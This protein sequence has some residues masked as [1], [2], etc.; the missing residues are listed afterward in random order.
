[1]RIYDKQSFIT[2]LDGAKNQAINIDINQTY[3]APK[4][5]SQ[6]H[7]ESFEKLRI[8]YGQF[9]KL[10]F[11]DRYF[12]LHYL[13]KG[14]I[15]LQLSE[16]IYSLKAPCFI[17][18]SPSVPHSFYTELDTVGHVLT[19][20]QQF[21][22][23]LLRSI[24]Q[25]NNYFQPL[26][27]E[28]AVDSSET[29]EIENILDKIV[30]EYEDSRPEKHTMLRLYAKIL[31]IN[32]ARLKEKNLQTAEKLPIKGGDIDLFNQFNQLIEQ[33]FRKNW[34]ISEYLTHLCISESRLNVLCKKFSG[35]S[36]K[37]IIIERQLQE[38]R[39]QLMFTQDSISKIAYDLGFSDP[40]YFSR[41][42]QARVGVSPKRFRDRDH[43]S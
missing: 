26:C 25:N 17:L 23:D 2:L 43:T 11:H 29:K 18:T 4:D 10:H 41:Y 7:Y 19:I 12:Q 35:L 28:L 30:E 14:A 22:W 6:I 20:P 33:N 42:F 27:I 5:G 36:P 16:N 8:F 39:Y 21:I 24:Q 37:Q 40:A 1:M 34:V 32:I 31:F 38:A 13:T 3:G 15:Y 9:S